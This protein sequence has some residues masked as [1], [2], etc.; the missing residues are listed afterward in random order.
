MANPLC[1]VFKLRF[2]TTERWFDSRLSILSY[3]VILKWKEKLIMWF[4]FFFFNLKSTIFVFKMTV[5]ITCLQRTKKDIHFRLHV[6]HVWTESQQRELT[7]SPFCCC[8]SIPQ[9]RSMTAAVKP[10]L[11]FFLARLLYITTYNL[12]YSYGVRAHL[13]S[14][15]YMRD[16]W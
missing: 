3:T 14:L 10:A 16:V 11:G 13:N 1:A 8:T 15:S 4:S 7:R 5:K 6:F 12:Y 9:S 2:D